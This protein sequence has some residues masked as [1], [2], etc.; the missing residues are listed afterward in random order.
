MNLET[1]NNTLS[2]LQRVQLQGN[3]APAFVQCVA[4]LQMEAQRIKAVQQ[5]QQQEPSAPDEE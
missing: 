5:A 1:I 4:A 3:E 2:F